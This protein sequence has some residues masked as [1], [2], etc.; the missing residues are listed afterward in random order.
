MQTN[1]NLPFYLYL[2]FV[3]SVDYKDDYKKL[4]FSQMNPFYL[5]GRSSKSMMNAS[6]NN[7]YY[8]AFQPVRF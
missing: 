4:H 7:F 1:L 6:L 3:W 5:L 8:K 2:Y